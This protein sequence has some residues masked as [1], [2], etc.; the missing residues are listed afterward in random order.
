M[1]LERG[2]R[3]LVGYKFTAGTTE[4]AW[5]LAAGDPFVER[6]PRNVSTRAD[7]DPA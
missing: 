3:S 5:G 6:I 4:W 1:R 7:R 2:G